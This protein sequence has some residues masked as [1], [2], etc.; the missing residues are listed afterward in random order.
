M[1]T[2]TKRMGTRTLPPYCTVWAAIEQDHDFV[3]P[4]VPT[5]EPKSVWL[6][7]DIFT[8][9]DLYHRRWVRTITDTIWATTWARS[10]WHIMMLGVALP[11][12]EEVRVLR[13][14]R[15]RSTDKLVSDRVGLYVTTRDALLAMEQMLP[16]HQWPSEMFRNLP[17]PICLH[18]QYPIPRKEIV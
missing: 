16:A 9:D 4:Y 15:S 7:P 2:P 13:R 6:H 8:P 1:T 17:Y 18:P 10:E 3:S 5:V 11:D 14:V 12:S